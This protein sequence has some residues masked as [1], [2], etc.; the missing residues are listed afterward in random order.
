MQDYFLFNQYQNKQMLKR[1]WQLVAAPTV[2][3]L[4]AQTNLEQDKTAGPILI[5]GNLT[6][7]IAEYHNNPTDWPGLHI[8][9]LANPEQLLKHL[10][11]LLFVTYPPDS[12]GILTYYDIRT[13]YYFFNFT[14]PEMLATYLGPIQ[15][16]KWHGSTWLD[17]QNPAWHEITNPT[18][19]DTS[20]KLQ[21][22]QSITKQQQQGLSLARQHK[23]IHDWSKKMLIPIEQTTQYFDQAI[24]LGLDRIAYLDQYMTLRASYPNKT[25]PA[26]LQGSAQYK[27]SHLENL[28]IVDR[29]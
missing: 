16:L 7:L 6:K 26:N 28:W 8:R 25:I 27:L 29:K 17:Q 10:R 4:F 9:S 22:Y 3:Y 19:A 12:K 20:N 15:I 14:E 1:I 2:E 21:A 24:K 11:A 23:Y 5:Y 18:N 13:L